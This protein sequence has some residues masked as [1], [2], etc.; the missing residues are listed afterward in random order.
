MERTFKRRILVRE[1][2]DGLSVDLEDNFH[3]FGVRLWVDG[4]ILTRVEGA[5]LRVPWETCPGAVDALQ[6]LEGL[7]VRSKFTI[8]ARAKAERHCTHLFDIAML[9]LDH[10]R[11][12]K[13]E[14]KT[15]MKSSRKTAMDLQK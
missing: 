4:N 7:D 11:L 13:N 10:L 5:A 14:Q 2:E 12:G 15:S 8:D 9:G 1:Q 3:R 6:D